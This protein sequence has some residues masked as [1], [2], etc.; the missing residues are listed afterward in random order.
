MLKFIL[1]SHPHLPFTR[2]VGENYI[3]FGISVHLKVLGG[4]IHLIPVCRGARFT[5]RVCN[6][7]RREVRIARVE[8]GDIEVG[9]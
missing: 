2:L 7:I 4:V 3:G 8:M 9:R 6:D 5:S 1:Y